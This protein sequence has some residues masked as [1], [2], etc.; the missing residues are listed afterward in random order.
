[1]RRFLISPLWC[2]S[3]GSTG[4]DKTCMIS[5]VSIGLLR[6]PLGALAV[7]LLNILRHPFVT[8]PVRNYWNIEHCLLA[9]RQILNI[10]SPRLKL[11][12]SLCLMSVQHREGLLP[13]FASSY[14]EI[15][16]CHAAGSGGHFPLVRSQAPGGVA[17]THQVSTPTAQTPPPI[18]PTRP[19]QGYFQN[20][21]E[22][23][24]SII[25]GIRV[26]E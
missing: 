20:G 15:S 14:E 26:W 6:C 1:M 5:K 19:P 9:L 12:R 23:L 22:F 4:T 7:L 18:H 3:S 25:F 17:I 10:N 24:N 8:A 13:C 16:V 21:T 2:Q 11:L